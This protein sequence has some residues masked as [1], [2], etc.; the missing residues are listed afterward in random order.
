MPT[1]S[2][3]GLSSLATA[4]FP[5]CDRAEVAGQLLRFW[6]NGEWAHSLT[7]SRGHSGGEDTCRG[8]LTAKRRPELGFSD[9]RRETEVLGAQ[10]ISGK[11]TEC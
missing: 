8:D 10:G 4:L 9:L 11:L 1:E 7:G 5:A 2:A 3:V 6:S